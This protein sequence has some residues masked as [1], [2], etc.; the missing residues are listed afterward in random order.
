MKDATDPIDIL[1]PPRQSHLVV[2]FTRITR[3]LHLAE[4]F[5]RQHTGPVLGCTVAK[6]KPSVAELVLHRCRYAAGRRA[7]A[8][9]LPGSQHNVPTLEDPVADGESMEHHVGRKQIRA[10]QPERPQ[11]QLLQCVLVRLPGNYLDDPP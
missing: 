4:G 1:Y 8:D 6:V 5:A 10:P 3:S 9:N 11:Y 7:S 2:Q